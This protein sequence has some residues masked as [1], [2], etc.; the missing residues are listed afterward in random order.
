MLF[1]EHAAWSNAKNL[2][3]GG[4]AGAVAATAVTPADVIKTRLQ[5][6]GDKKASAMHIARDLL[7]EGGVGALFSGLGPRLMRIPMYTAVTLATFDFVKDLFQASNLR[8]AVSV[9]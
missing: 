8:A 2:I 9:A 4:M 3:A 5:A 7:S 1:N 6:R